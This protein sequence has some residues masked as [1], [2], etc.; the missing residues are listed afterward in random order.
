MNIARCIAEEQRCAEEMMVDS[1]WGLVGKEDWAM[2]R[3][4]LEGEVTHD[5]IVEKLKRLEAA[6]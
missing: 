6:R 4:L 3:K 2:E 1:A 5:E